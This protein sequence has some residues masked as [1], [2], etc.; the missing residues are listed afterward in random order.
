MLI[1]FAITLAAWLGLLFLTTNLIGFLVRGLVP[2]TSLNILPSEEGDFINGVI[3]EHRRSGRVL[4]LVPL[5]LL[6]AVLVALYHFWNV[7][8]VLA[9]VMLMAARVPDLIWELKHGRRLGKLDMARPA[10]HSLTTII[11]W[12]SLPMLWYALYRM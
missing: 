6:A 10:L 11:M 7:G 8:V 1:Q 12:L 4:S 9:A 2:D 3:Q 5:L